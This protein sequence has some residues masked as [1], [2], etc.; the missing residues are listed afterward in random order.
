MSFIE[1]ITGI[2]KN[3][4]KQQTLE[5][6][7]PVLSFEKDLMVMK[8]GRVAIGFAFDG[9][10]M[11]QWSAN[12]YH[13]AGQVFDA[14]LKSLPKNSIVQKIDIY[15]NDFLSKEKDLA[16]FESKTVDHYLARPVL[17][18]KSYFFIIS[19]ND[20]NIKPNEVNN[21]FA[22]FDKI[23]TKTALKNIEGRLIEW[24]KIAPSYIQELSSINNIKFERLGNE[25]LK[26]LY[27][28]MLNMEF[29][30]DPGMPYKSI[31]NK[32]N[33][34][35]IGDKKLNV[36]SMTEQSKI[37]DYSRQCEYGVTCPFT[38]NVGI[39]MQTPHLGITSYYVDDTEKELLRLDRERKLNFAATQFGGEDPKLKDEELRLMT[40]DIRT[41][42]KRIVSLSK[43]L[44]IYTLGEQ[45]RERN[46]TN[47][48]SEIRT[49]DSAN[50][51]LESY[52]NAGM[53][54]ACLPGNASETVR[55]ITMPSDV[56]TCYIDFTTSFNGSHSGDLVA[57]RFGNLV[58]INLFNRDLMNQNC[59]IIGPSGSGK[60]FT[61]GH[62]IVQRYERR[63]RQIMIDVGGTYKNIFE[64][65]GSND[66]KSGVKYFEYDPEKPLSF[67]PF[68]VT[69]NNGKFNLSDDKI[70]FILSL[71]SQLWSGK[72]L[73][74][75][76][77]AI[78]S[79]WIDLYYENASEERNKNPDYIPTL[80]EFYDWLIKYN[81]EK[82]TSKNAKHA[83]HIVAFNDGDL[84]EGFNDFMIVLS[85]YTH[86]KYKSLLN[87]AERLDISEYP[88]VCFDMARVK[89]NIELYPL[90]TMLL[91]ELSMDVV[92]K[93]PDDIKHFVMDE[94]WSMLSDGMGTFVEYMYRTLRKN[95][96]AMTIITQGVGEIVKS[97][98]G[99]AII[100]NA[101]TKIILNHSDLN[102]VEDLGRH[103][104]FTNDEVRKIAS[105]RKG[106]FGR[107][108]FIKQG[109]E[110]DV[111][112]IDV[113]D[114][115]HA[116]LTSNPVERN[117]LNK[118]KKNYNTL[119]YAI[120]QWVEDKKSGVFNNK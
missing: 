120:N 77:K 2:F 1:S 37:I 46:I 12:D 102:K 105:L 42:Q 58:H 83:S 44:I 64:A 112:S 97:K 71:F 91:T 38:Y 40:E 19:P 78:I 15:Y 86:G 80:K 59:L 33:Y 76:V 4:K 62:F 53:F 119:N 74:K 92:R 55:W 63:E 43:Q 6:L 14:S 34:L 117:H 75:S 101:D 13:N 113:C 96:G 108:I 41:N 89:D 51:L 31:D 84:A 5:K 50:A 87:N 52:Y 21:T 73:R 72:D 110:S 111:F 100:G 95:N 29:R 114:S 106:Q 93:F 115:E 18:H 27:R 79:E 98:V 104:G 11:E 20:S 49:W 45:A 48:I 99:E 35:V 17:K 3:E 66:P 22:S 118:L 16:Y 70:D 85:A 39:Y 7:L 25:Q 10:E 36:L 109:A 103:L 81:E 67:N 30:F 82:T 47:A 57:D 68:L 65:L 32:D 90:V 23:N 69:F 26:E 28:Q 107:E 8:N 61:K 24:Q 60:S 94:A 116:I 54:F 56:A 9:V 88:L